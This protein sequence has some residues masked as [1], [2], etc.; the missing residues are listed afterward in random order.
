MMTPI[1]IERRVYSFDV[2]EFLKSPFKLELVLLVVID[3]SI[4]GYACFC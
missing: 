2:N 1:E 4:G 3:V